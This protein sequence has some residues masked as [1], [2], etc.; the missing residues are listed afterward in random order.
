VNAEG[1]R[2]SRHRHA[3]IIQMPDGEAFIEF[4]H[5]SAG[6][7][8]DVNGLADLKPTA[9]VAIPVSAARQAIRAITA[10]Q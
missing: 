9:T 10:A 2:D 8:V 7:A 4:E 5:W 6:D 3:A 1:N